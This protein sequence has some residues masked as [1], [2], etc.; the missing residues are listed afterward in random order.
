MTI[1]HPMKTTLGFCTGRPLEPSLISTVEVMISIHIQKQSLV[2]KSYKNIKTK[3]PRNSL[4]STAK[5]LFLSIS[6]MV[7][8]VAMAATCSNRNSISTKAILLPIIINK[9][10]NS[11]RRGDVKKTHYPSQGQ[12]IRHHCA[13]AYTSETNKTQLDQISDKI[14]VITTN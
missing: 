10:N 8:T 6:A 14:L 9:H 13:L 2:A 12:T 7:T 4:F 5:P 11:Y 1:N 3:Y